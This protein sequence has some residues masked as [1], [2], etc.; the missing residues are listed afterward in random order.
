MKNLISKKLALL[1][2]VLFASIGHAFGQ[3]ITFDFNGV[4][5]NGYNADIYVNWDYWVSSNETRYFTAGEDVTIEVYAYN[6]YKLDKVYV[7]GIEIAVEDN[8]AKHVFESISGN[9]TVKVVCQK[10]PTKTISLSINYPDVADVC[11]IGTN[12]TNY[13]LCYRNTEEVE[14][15]TGGNIRLQLEPFSTAYSVNSVKVDGNDVTSAFMAGNV[16][17]TNISTNHT[18]EVTYE[19]IASHTITTSVEDGKAFYVED[20]ESGTKFWWPGTIELAAGKDVRLYYEP[21][22]GYKVDNASIKK[23]DGSVVNIAD[24][25]NTQGYYELKSLDA[26]YEV[27]IT[28][29]EATQHTVSVN[30]DH[31]KGW[32][33]LKNY[34]S[35]PDD[36]FYSY[37]ADPNT[38]YAFNEGTSVRLTFGVDERIYVLKSIEIDGTG[39]TPNYDDGHNYYYCDISTLSADHSVVVNF[40]EKPS[41]TVNFDEYLGFVE[42]SDYGN[43]SSGYS[44]VYDNG[45]TVRITPYA[46]DGYKVGSITINGSAV[47]LT[48]GYYEFTLSDKCTVNVVFEVAPIYSIS[49]TFNREGFAGV[50]VSWPNGSRIVSSSSS[51]N[52]L[53]GSDV[54]MWTNWI[55]DSYQ[56]KSFKVGDVDYTD[57]FTSGDFSL[58]NVTSNLSV[59]VELETI[60]PSNVFNVSFN[61]EGFGDVCISDNHIGRCVSQSKIIDVTSGDDIWVSVNLFSSAHPLKMI[62]VDNVDVTNEFKQHDGYSIPNNS[63]DHSIYVEYDILESNTI[64][65]ILQEGDAEIKFEDGDIAVWGQEALFAKGHSVKMYLTPTAGSEISSVSIDDGSNIQD[66][67]SYFQANGGYYEFTSLN[68]DYTVTVQFTQVDTRTITLNYNNERGSV[69]INDRGAG[70]YEFTYNLGSTIRLTT[71]PR[72][73]YKVGSIFVGEEEVT[74]FYNTNGYYEFVLNSNSAIT[75]NFVEATYYIVSVSC[76]NPENGYYS[77]NQE[78][79]VIEGADINLSVNPYTGYVPIVTDNGAVVVLTQEH[80]SYYYEINDLDADHTINVRFDEAE[81]SNIYLSINENETVVSLNNDSRTNSGYFKLTTGITAR[82]VVDPQIGYELES[83]IIDNDDV[84]DDYKANGY[85]DLVVKECIISVTMKKKLA[86]EMVPFTLSDLGIGTFCYEFDLDFSNVRGIKAY[87]ASGFNPIS[88]Q[89][90]LTKVDEVPAGTGILIKGSSGDYQIPTTE[91]YF[92]YANMLKGVVK[93][94]YIPENSWE[95]EWNGYGLYA[96]YLLGDDGEF[97]RTNGEDLPANSAYLTIP[98]KY[99]DSSSL[100]KIGLIFVDDEEEVGGIT[101]GVGYIWAGENRTVTTDAI[102]NLQGQKIT[103]KSLK[104]GIYIKNGKKFMVK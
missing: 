27:S 15:P 36:Y 67:S 51:I 7:D 46:Y 98:T 102:Y 3:S 62:K 8:T 49:Y 12:G 101:T 65:V 57:L 73:G 54:Y 97:Y 95:E 99:V 28:T 66:V 92:C 89:L 77:L 68:A 50:N 70:P 53:E 87:V 22:V 64:S 18:V 80:G 93:D 59:Y 11:F 20:V 75:V 44:Y 37:N 34:R 19:K 61:H 60:Q 94:T 43:V 10:L 41:V 30:F 56:V 45:S 21:Y 17:F 84:T 32:V 72:G 91:T 103:E 4:N 86:P 13:G 63:S 69:Y 104:P 96:H 24:D 58:P 39:V 29:K 81:T 5:D 35:D 14:V 78:G 25:L 79:D 42:L 33:N 1:A 90:V 52:V 82:L 85:Y 100:A 38:S 48:D 2:I 9:H 55:D 83:I 74:N 88:K 40:E 23:S 47:S 31:V 26:D 6:T 16:T 76:D 71:N